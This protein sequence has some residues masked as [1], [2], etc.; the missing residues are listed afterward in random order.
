MA[1]KPQK[2]IAQLTAV[3]LTD[4]RGITRNSDRCITTVFIQDQNYNRIEWL[5]FGQVQLRGYDSSR[6][7]GESMLQAYLSEGATDF[8]HDSAYACCLP[9]IGVTYEGVE[10]HTT[11]LHAWVHPAA[12]DRDSAV[13]FSVPLPGYNP[14]KHKDTVI[15]SAKTCDEKHPIVPEG[16][17]WPPFEKDLYRLVR[18]Q[19][20]EISIGPVYPQEK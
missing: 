9:L 4:L 10:Y 14:M 11:R 5:R 2:P 3:P 20:V 16:M 15:C 12:G 18:G 13:R 6:K 17:Y 8:E 19:K 7:A 1:E